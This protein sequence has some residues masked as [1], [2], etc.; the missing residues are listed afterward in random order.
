VEPLEGLA[1]IAVPVPVSWMPHT[2]G[3]AALGVVL[4]GLAVWAIVSWRR[5]RERNRYRRE[6]LVELTRTANEDALT[7]IPPLLKRVALS[8]WPRSEVAALSGE[9]WVSFLRAH[10]PFPEDAARL[11][12]DLEYRPRAP[13]EDI[14]L[15][16]HASRLWIEKHVRA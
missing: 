5:R 9:A 15:L 16:V 10:G 7:V 11:L 12:G 1:D 3:W 4:L 8:A 14:D 6:A 13:G 2:W